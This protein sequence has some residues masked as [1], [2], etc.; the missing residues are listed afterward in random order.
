MQI[1]EHLFLI[2]SG[3]WGF[4]LTHPK[5][6]NVYLV[7]TG[8][9]LVA[10]DAGTGLGGEQLRRIVTSHGLCLNELRAIFL[11]HNHAD[12]TCGAAEL[13][14]QTGCTIYASSPEAESIAAA[15]EQATGFYLARGG[16]P[17]GFCYPRGMRVTPLDDEETVTIGSL[18]FRAHHVPGHSL[19]DLV[20]SAQIDARA[21]LFTGDAV[22]AGGEILLQNLADVCIYDYG[23]AVS[24]LAALPVDA[25][26]PGHGLFCLS[27]GDWHVRQC[28]E[29]FA[30][31]LIPRQLHYF[32]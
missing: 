17:Q 23:K 14:Q 5:D 13:Q 26:L 28:A 16:Y 6:C 15:D 12:H 7:D 18:T 22:F 8:D 31:G 4:G 25:L 21:C 19:C 30:S 3:K 11:T 9:G 2:A 1:S 10:I 32:A 29:A 24:K 27:E 20:L